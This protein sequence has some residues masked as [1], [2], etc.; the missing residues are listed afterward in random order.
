MY[1]RQIQA[2]FS[3]YWGPYVYAHYRTEQE[4]IGRIHDLL[5]L[6]IFSFFCL[7]VVFEGII[8]IIFPAK[9][10]FLP[11]FPLMMLA[12]VF[13]IPVSYT[14]LDVYKRQNQ[15]GRL[16]AA[17]SGR[18]SLSAAGSRAARRRSQDVYKRQAPIGLLQPAVPAPVRNNPSCGYGLY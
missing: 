16:L 12:V 17:G 15:D 10:A 18:I 6:L 14:H 3:T 5:N 2:G 4:R 11:Y 7:L 13:S 1:K 9:S 8:F